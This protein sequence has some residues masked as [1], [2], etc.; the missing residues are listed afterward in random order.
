MTRKSS[1]S[2]SFLLDKKSTKAESGPVALGCFDW[3]PE[4]EV[5]FVSQMPVHTCVR[6]CKS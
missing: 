3:N 5:H 1:R 2:V 4:R 6:V